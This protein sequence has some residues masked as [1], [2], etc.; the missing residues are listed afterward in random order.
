MSAITA[1]DCIDEYLRMHTGQHGD[2]CEKCA[3]CAEVK[4]LRS[5][6]ARVEAVMRDNRASDGKWYIEAGELVRRLEAALKDTP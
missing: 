4:R 1:K 3:L 6:L 2:Y 5:K